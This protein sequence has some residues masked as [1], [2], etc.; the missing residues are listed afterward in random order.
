MKNMSFF[1]ANRCVDDK[2]FEEIVEFMTDDNEGVYF[3]SKEKAEE[4]MNRINKDLPNN[5][6]RAN[7]Y[8]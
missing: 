6:E 7:E 1:N 8:Y 3:T 2:T 5:L 4:F